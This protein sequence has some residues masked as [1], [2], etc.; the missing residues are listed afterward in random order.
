MMTLN[1]QS[2]SEEATDNHVNENVE[3]CR[4]LIDDSN[5]EEGDVH[6]VLK[7]LANFGYTHSN[8]QETRNVQGVKLNTDIC[9]TK[10]INDVNSALSTEDTATTKGNC[11][12][13]ATSSSLQF[14]QPYSYPATSNGNLASLAISENI[15]YTI[16]QCANC[17]AKNTP[18]W[19]R[20]PE[21]KLLL[22]NACGLYIKN[23]RMHR[24]VVKAPDGQLVVDRSN[25]TS[26]S[27][28]RDSGHVN[29]KGAVSGGKSGKKSKQDTCATN[30]KQS[31]KSITAS[32]TGAIAWMPCYQC[33]QLL[34]VP[35]TA[36]IKSS[37]VLCEGCWE[38]D[39]DGKS[40]L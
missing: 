18:T 15:T 10:S 16:K 23:H 9:P 21:G 7:H 31:I 25:T 12:P 37:P 33:S 3:E 36:Y 2:V 30:I 38:K 40:E 26:L 20:C 8:N 35:M 6:N 19:R 22:C 28:G 24:K 13:I 39:D 4:D 32:K 11:L 34:I 5:N 1:E 29:S 27:T 14:Y 17:G